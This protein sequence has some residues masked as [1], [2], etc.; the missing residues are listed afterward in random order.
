[1]IARPREHPAR[2]RRVCQTVMV[3][4]G[5]GLLSRFCA[6]YQRNTG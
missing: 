2:L 3:D 6:H 4:E 1:M 5:E